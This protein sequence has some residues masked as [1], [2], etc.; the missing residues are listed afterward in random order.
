MENETDKIIIIFAIVFGL[1]G[2]Y[3]AIDDG[4]YLSAQ[5]RDLWPDPFCP[6][7]SSQ[8]SHREDSFS[9]TS[10]GAG[11]SDTTTEQGLLDSCDEILGVDG[12]SETGGGQ[13]YID[14][15]CAGEP[16]WIIPEDGPAETCIEC[17]Q[18]VDA[19]GFVMDGIITKISD[20]SCGVISCPF[21]EIGHAWDDCCSQL[22]KCINKWRSGEFACSWGVDP[23]EFGGP[24]REPPEG[25]EGC[26]IECPP[27]PPEGGGD[28]CL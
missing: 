24:P 18:W 27:D 12:C 26:A 14:C 21:P 22:V 17:G 7:R 15:S 13:I 9:T 3:L 20:G 16:L 25:D 4:V 6:W 2:I 23:G 8:Y 5:E 10:P 28:Y 19:D 11:L 1:V